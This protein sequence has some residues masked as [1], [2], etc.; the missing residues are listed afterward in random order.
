MGNVIYTK[1]EAHRKIIAMTK[2]IINSFKVPELSVKSSR[3]GVFTISVPGFEYTYVLENGMC[4]IQSTEPEAAFAE[5]SGIGLYNLMTHIFD[6]G[7]LV[8][9]RRMTIKNVLGE[10]RVFESGKKVVIKV[11]WNDQ[12]KCYVLSIGELGKPF[13]KVKQF[14][15]LQQALYMECRLFSF[16]ALGKSKYWDVDNDWE[17]YVQQ[18]VRKTALYA[19][20]E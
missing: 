17:M 7:V 18:Y 8:L 13:F 5:F 10:K 2:E 16:V 9:R 15:D 14:D 20:E 12:R 1:P 3:E 6:G 19:S 11:D 4:T